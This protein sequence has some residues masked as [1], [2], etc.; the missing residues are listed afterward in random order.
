[1][2]HRFKQVFY[3]PGLFLQAMVGVALFPLTAVIYIY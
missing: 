2:L 1:M 3:I